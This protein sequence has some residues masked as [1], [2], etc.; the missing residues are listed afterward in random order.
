[1]SW[2]YWA[3]QQDGVTEKRAQ[4]V[5]ATLL[6]TRTKGSGLLAQSERPGKVMLMENCCRSCKA[7]GL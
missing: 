4:L 7:V 5:A 3:L 2:N 1:M 6:E